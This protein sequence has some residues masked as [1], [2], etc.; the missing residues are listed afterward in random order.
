DGGALGSEA[1]AA[2]VVGGALAEV[3]GVQVGAEDDELV[4]LLG[5]AD[6]ANRVVDGDGAGDELVVDLQLDAGAGRLRPAG[7]PPELGVALVGDAQARQG[8]AGVRPL[9]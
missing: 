3:P 4:R 6:L 8:L 5:A 1:R 7:Q 9:A 2:A